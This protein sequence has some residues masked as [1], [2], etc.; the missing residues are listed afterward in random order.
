[1]RLIGGIEL[2]PNTNKGGYNT[3]SGRTFTI[4]GSVVLMVTILF[5]PKFSWDMVTKT[6]VSGVMLRMG[7]GV[8]E[9]EWFAGN[10]THLRGISETG[11]ITGDLEGTY[12][13]VGNY[14]LNL[15]TGEGQ[16]CGKI[17]LILTWNG[18]SGTFEGT[19]AGKLSDFGVSLTIW[20][21]AQGIS[22]D[23]V[24]MKFL[25]TAIWSSLDE[26]YDVEGFILDPH[27]E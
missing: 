16:S 3:M 20:G 5:I 11:V 7:V 14:H 1:M 13:V 21:V 10:N 19:Y 12:S 6:E 22:G 4:M 15:S 9:K 23:F 17:T 18:L 8:P 27:G 25:G 26:S 24:G 2:S